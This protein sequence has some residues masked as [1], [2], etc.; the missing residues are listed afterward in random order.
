M[1][2]I[3]MNY[4]NGNTYDILYP[5]GSFNNMSGNLTA[6]Q[7]P[8]LDASKINSGTLGTSRIPNLSA[9]KITSGVLGVDRIPNLDMS[10]ITTGNLAA[11]RITGLSDQ[12]KVLEWDYFSTSFSTSVSSTWNGGAL[13]KKII[14]LKELG[15]VPE[16]YFACFFLLI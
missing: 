6:S 8:N 13:A 14:D 16:N 4:F 7:V 1:A 9:S 3:E 12:T 2:N 15:I 10:K 11:N 5:K